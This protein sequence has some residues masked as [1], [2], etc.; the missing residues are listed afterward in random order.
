MKTSPFD[1]LYMWIVGSLSVFLP[2]CLADG[3]LDHQ[4]VTLAPNDFVRLYSV[5]ENAE[6]SRTLTLKVD[7]GSLATGFIPR[8]SGWGLSE[9]SSNCLD[10]RH[11]SFGI[12]KGCPGTS[13]PP[14]VT[15]GYTGTPAQNPE[16]QFVT[17][18]R[19]KFRECHIPGGNGVQ[20][21]GNGQA[22]TSF[23]NYSVLI[24]DPDTVFVDPN[25]AYTRRFSWTKFSAIRWTSTTTSVPVSVTWSLEDADISSDKV[26]MSE[27]RGVTSLTTPTEG[28]EMWFSN[29]VTETKVVKAEPEGDQGEISVEIHVTDKAWTIV[30]APKYVPISK[31]DEP[32]D[33]YGAPIVIHTGLCEDAF[34]GFQVEFYKDEVRTED[35]VWKEGAIY[36]DL[37]EIRS[38]LVEGGLESQGHRKGRLLM[39][40][41]TQPGEYTARIKVMDRG[42]GEI[43]SYRTSE[44][45]FKA[46]GVRMEVEPEDV[47]GLDLAEGEA[48]L[49]PLRKLTDENPERR[50]HIGFSFE[51]NLILVSEEDFSSSIWLVDHAS[52]SYDFVKA[53]GDAFIKADDVDGSAAS[54]D[55]SFRTLKENEG[56]LSPTAAYKLQGTLET[57]PVLIAITNG[58][59]RYTIPRT[60]GLE[61]GELN[62]NMSAALSAKKMVCA[63]LAIQ[64]PEEAKTVF[65]LEGTEGKCVFTVEGSKFEAL[66]DDTASAV[67]DLL[68][69]SIE[70]AGE[71]EAE[72]AA[73]EDQEHQQKI[74]YG[75]MPAQNGDFGEKD[76]ALRFKDRE[77]WAVNKE[78]TLRFFRDGKGAADQ[79]HEDME[80]VE[81]GNPNWYVYW[82]Q[83]A[84]EVDERFALQAEKL[85]YSE[86]PPEN[87]R[88][89][90]WTTLGQC[91]SSY[92]NRLRITSEIIMY[93]NI[94]DE[95][96][97]RHTAR[98]V[99]FVRT[100]HHENAHHH[101]IGLPIE[102]GGWGEEMIYLRSLDTDRDFVADSWERTDDGR[103][104][105]MVVFEP[106]PVPDGLS[107]DER[108]EWEREQEEE[109]VRLSKR[110]HF[111]DGEWDHGWATP[112]EVEAATQYSNH[113]NG[114]VEEKGKGLCVDY[115]RQVNA[116]AEEIKKLDWSYTP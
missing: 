83:V 100:L 45:T 101:A 76:L 53:D 15:I 25:P 80:F 34:G 94:V 41:A 77:A 32:L 24:T 88:G 30:G 109:R 102:I 37:N 115:E 71:V 98:I 49:V 107:E 79:H 42:F 111:M 104:L 29:R 81:E 39:V 57:I 22:G 9:E 13:C 56:Y 19:G 16:R 92:G 82:Q 2:V 61:R 75:E 11:W 60:G 7:S 72:L 55:L 48:G 18:I 44:C 23:T 84:G 20:G 96:I 62:H 4:E 33:T 116:K 89:E 5:P 31:S 17:R 86:D 105:G 26:R 36:D 54:T 40:T 43:P 113:P 74:T 14:E 52:V 110:D 10:P 97:D 69:W 87:A 38:G 70:D 1:I 68:E 50:E 67:W 3:L 35:V 93:N 51:G 66:S 108:I 73:V 112:A 95:R 91:V 103:G 65:D 78:V 99:L 46:V 106:D 27:N 114:Y 28:T 47:L 63:D 90:E 58:A 85:K 64:D 59:P 8:D 21:G 6:D 12:S